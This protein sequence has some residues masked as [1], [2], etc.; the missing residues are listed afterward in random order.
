MHYRC[1]VIAIMQKSQRHEIILRIISAT[2]LRSQDELASLLRKNGFNVTQASVS[3]DLDQLGIVKVKGF[4]TIPQNEFT[5]GT[6]AP[7]S[8]ETAGENLIILKLTPGMA[9]AA[10]VVIDGAGIQEVVGTIAGD[11]TIFVAV[12]DATGQKQAIRHILELF[13]A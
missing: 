1:I 2:K 5:A 10:A 4:Y 7:L 9:S 6:P 8:V 13:A 3:R 12:K 11:D